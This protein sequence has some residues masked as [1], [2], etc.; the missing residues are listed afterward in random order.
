MTLPQCKK[1]FYISDNTVL[2]VYVCFLSV[3]VSFSLYLYLC[4]LLS[5]S[6]LLN[7]SCITMEELC[8]TDA[9]QWFK[10]DKKTQNIN[11]TELMS[12]QFP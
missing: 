4:V 11:I 9:S 3:C 7:V 10:I 1:T 2:S 6:Q 12:D 5:G 8:I